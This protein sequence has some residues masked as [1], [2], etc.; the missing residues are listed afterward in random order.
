MYI[1]G[2]PVL[3]LFKKKN[4]FRFSADSRSF[5][6]AVVAVFFF[7]SVGREFNGF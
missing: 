7:L 6:V 5:V 2:L 4:P 3:V 1:F